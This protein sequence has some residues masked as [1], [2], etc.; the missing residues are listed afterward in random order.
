MKSCKT[1]VWARFQKE[2][3]NG[4]GSCSMPICQRYADADIMLAVPVD[5]NVFM[6]RIDFYCLADQSL[7]RRWQASDQSKSC[8]ILKKA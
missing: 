1:V 4:D 6:L 7:W 5:G 3:E 8:A 2:T